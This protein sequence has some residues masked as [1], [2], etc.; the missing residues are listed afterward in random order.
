MD[1]L[2]K[3]S[4][5]KI[6]CAVLLVLA[7]G[8]NAFAQEK[9]PVQMLID[10]YNLPDKLTAEAAK[11]TISELNQALTL[12][13]DNTLR[14]RI[15]YRIGMIY[16][17]AG[18]LNKAVSCFEK[19]T[20][21]AECCDLIK[22]CSFNMAGQVYRMQAKDDKALAAFEELIEHSKKIV[23]QEPNQANPA[24]VLKLAVTAGFAKAEIY[25]YNENY[26][27]AI[28]E[29]RKIIA[30]VKDKD[31][32]APNYVP[33]TKDRLSQAY[34]IEG[35]VEDYNQ[36]SAELAQ[37][38][39]DYYRVPIVRLETEAVRILKEKDASINFPKGS[40]DAPARLIALVKDSGDK[41]FKEKTTS[42]FKD[43]YSRYQQGYGGLL[44][45]YHYAW[46]L[47]AAEKQSQ[48]AEVL[49]AVCKQAASINT[50][51]PGIV[52]V[53]STLTDY[54]K[55]Q[56]AVIFGEENKYKEALELVY[57]LKPDPNDV[58]M[59]NLSNSIENALQT[60]KREVPKDA[61]DQ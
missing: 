20:R 6:V 34:L 17:K 56:Q 4:Y 24:A 7:S 40:F 32:F 57:S 13:T 35:K 5:R 49:E 30:F 29:Y 11:R 53:I 28:G 14:H 59:Q 45:G 58:H 60:L 2:K 16:F 37:K 54:A 33:L 42:I 27:S 46:L 55:L 18:D 61:N 12:C 10:S 1:T 15:E 50:D 47:D 39:P 26:D 23:S 52:H 48:A 19:I 21:I 31:P 44:L 22:L 3:E 36:A 43:L 41:E 9:Q 25:Q 8:L 38:Y 51:M